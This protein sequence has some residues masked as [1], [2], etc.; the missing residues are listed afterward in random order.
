MELLDLFASVVL[1]TE[2]LLAE[3]PPV[4]TSSGA[5][6]HMDGNMVESHPMEIFR[7]AHMRILIVDDLDSRQ[8]LGDRMTT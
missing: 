2:E 4:R 1:R 6:P 3:S 8:K 5:V 7:V